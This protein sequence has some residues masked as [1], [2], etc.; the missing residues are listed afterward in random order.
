MEDTIKK[1]IVIISFSKGLTSKNNPDYSFDI[2]EFLTR[3]TGK[4][5]EG[6]EF[7]TYQTKSG[8]GDIE[9]TPEVDPAKL[10]FG[11]VAVGEFGEVYDSKN[12][13]NVLGLVGIS[14]ILTPSPLDLETAFQK[15]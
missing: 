15:K 12:R 13:V 6:K 5:R 8:I 11:T 14:K 4:D 2:C 7:V 9:L 1:T 3:K 10:R